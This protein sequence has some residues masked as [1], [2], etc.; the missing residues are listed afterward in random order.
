[1]LLFDLGMFVVLRYPRLLKLSSNFTFWVSLVFF[2]IIVRR[3]VD[4]I[5]YIM[6]IIIKSLGNLTEWTY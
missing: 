5:I 6:F 4:N 1:M 3:L 2:F